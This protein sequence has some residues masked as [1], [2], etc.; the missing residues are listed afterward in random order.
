[1]NKTFT[2]LEFLLMTENELI[3]SEGDWST[4]QTIF[5]L[6]SPEPSKSS[7]DKVLGFA[8]TYDTLKT[9]SIGFIEL[10]LN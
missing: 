8:D 7:L 6:S 9:Q 10:N 1:M 2:W 3:E 5:R 4:N